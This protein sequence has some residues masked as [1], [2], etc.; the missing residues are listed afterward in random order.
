MAVVFEGFVEGFES[1]EGVANG[2][3]GGAEFER[4]SRF[5]FVA[6]GDGLVCESG[7]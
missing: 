3:L 4:C 1:A 2:G 6:F 7:C 5:D